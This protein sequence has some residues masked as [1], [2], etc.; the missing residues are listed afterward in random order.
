[1]KEKLKKKTEKHGMNLLKIISCFS[2]CAVLKTGTCVL[3]PVPVALA[4]HIATGSAAVRGV[5]D[6]FDQCFTFRCFEKHLVRGNTRQ[7]FSQA[8][9][10]L[11]LSGCLS[12]V[13]SRDVTEITAVNLS[14][15]H[16][17]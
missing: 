1:M 10:R 12:P 7:S 5:L 2:L 16:I 13:S 3:V 11:V 4:T 17:R 15:I 14:F 9:P 8:A 6:C